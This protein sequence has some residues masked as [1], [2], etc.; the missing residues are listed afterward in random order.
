M[1]RDFIKF[2]PSK[3]MGQNFLID[4]EIVLSICN[5]L[6]DFVQYDAILEIGPGI[7]AITEHLVSL[8]KPLFCIE[9]DKRL[10]TGLK[11]KFQAYKNLVLINDDVLKVDFAK[12]F[13]P[14]KKV[15]IVANIP[16]N[17]TSPII[18]KCLNEVKIDAMYL[19][20]QKE[21]ARKLNY[22]KTTNRNAFVNIV[23]YYYNVEI[24]FDISPKSFSPQPEVYSSFIG[25]QRK[26]FEPLNWQFF[27]FIKPFFLSK[28]KKLLNNIHPFVM[29]EVMVK[30]LK[31]NNIDL[32]VR[33]ENLDYD[34]FMKMFHD[35]RPK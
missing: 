33:A 16:Y 1:S 15:I 30:W 29:K 22:H 14:H 27:K 25:L 19:M 10:F 3:Q 6:P 17:I 9:L 12:L 21:V 20:V 18:L 23:N 32:N 31:Q 24:F 7:G 13:Q 28:R 5:V 35:L 26:R 11:V 8:N 4:K 2:F 34:I